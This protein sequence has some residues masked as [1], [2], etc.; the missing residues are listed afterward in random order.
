[1]IVKGSRIDAVGADL[2]IPPGA[3]VIDLGDATILPG[4]IDAHVHLTQEGSE[5]WFRDFYEDI[6]RFPAEQAH[7]AALYARRTL[8]A[9]C[10][11]QRGAKRL[12][13]GLQ[14]D[15][16]RNRS[17]SAHA[18]RFTPSARRAAATAA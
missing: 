15:Q 12:R 7:Y 10:G 1:M 5:N 8:E 9:A 13:T 17:G 6:M 14:R 3:R 11:P 18:R 2:P 4:L 16:R